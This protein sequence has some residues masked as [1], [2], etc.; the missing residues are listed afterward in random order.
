VEVPRIPIHQLQKHPTPPLLKTSAHVLAVALL[1]GWVVTATDTWLHV[2]SS[3][4]LLTTSKAAAAGEEKFYG[5][6]LSAEC[7]KLMGFYLNDPRAGATVGPCNVYGAGNGGAQ[8]LN[9]EQSMTAV[10]NISSNNTAALVDGYTI[11]VPTTPDPDIDYKASTFALQASCKPASIACGLISQKHSVKFNCSRGNTFPIFSGDTE[12]TP[13][14]ETAFAND[15]AATQRMDSGTRTNPFRF[16]YAAR[17]PLV[18]LSLAYDLEVGTNSATRYIAI[19]TCEMGVFEVAIP[20]RL[21]TTG[22]IW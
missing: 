16:A 19:F 13:F 4:V 10:L 2:A 22:K 15:S 1:I 8:L 11:M 3:T 14:F 17:F 9:S 21:L 12:K 6:G 7:L 18:P 5:R 20:P